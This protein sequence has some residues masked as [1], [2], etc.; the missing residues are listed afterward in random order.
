MILFLL[1]LFINKVY[2]YENELIVS[3][4]RLRVR[5]EENA[6]AFGIL[7]TEKI[8]YFN[9]T[10]GDLQIYQHDY[11]TN[12]AWKYKVGYATENFTTIISISKNNILYISQLYINILDYTPRI[13]VSQNII[14]ADDTIIMNKGTFTGNN[15]TVNIGSISA[16]YSS[17]F[18]SSYTKE[19]YWT[20]DSEDLFKNQNYAVIIVWIDKTISNEFFI[21][22]TDFVFSKI[23]YQLYIPVYAI[24]KEFIDNV[25]INIATAHTFN[26]DESKITSK[27]Y[28]NDISTY[29]VYKITID[30]IS[31]DKAKYI[32]DNISTY[33]KNGLY[34][35]K[36]ININNVK[37]ENMFLFDQPVIEN[38]YVTTY[39]DKNNIR[40]YIILSLMIILFI[41]TQS[42]TFYFHLLINSYKTLLSELIN[43]TINKEIT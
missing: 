7:D 16:S 8:D 25:I 21:Y 41:L 31:V 35:E 10:I 39:I 13:T 15:I 26:L 22:K 32:N 37:V 28:Q 43:V 5:P 29:Q 6:Y 30:F 33:V 1:F 24:E 12:W 23:E 19:W 2:S 40:F 11:T 4:S 27:E 34:F 20:C 42:Q 9:C 3:S 38:R 18:L 17:S 36:I 14:Q